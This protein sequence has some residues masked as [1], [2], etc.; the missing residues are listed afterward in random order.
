MASR[1]PVDLHPA[2]REFWFVLQR[3]AKSR[4]G[5]DIFLTA[6]YRSNAE[7]TELYLLETLVGTLDP[8]GGPN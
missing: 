5:L 2:M 7:Q 4:L 8:G 3:L 1:N 6:T